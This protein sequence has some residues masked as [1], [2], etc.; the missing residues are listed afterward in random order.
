MILGCGNPQLSV[1]S[2]RAA[3]LFKEVEYPR[4]DYHAKQFIFIDN[5]R[6]D[7]SVLVETEETSF[8]CGREPVGI[9]LDTCDEWVVSA[10]SM[11]AMSRNPSFC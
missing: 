8:Y 4:H 5:K 7:C 11:N 2:R 3:T 6:P 10:N 9:I 1:F